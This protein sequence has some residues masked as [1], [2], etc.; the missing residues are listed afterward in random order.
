MWNEQELQILTSILEQIADEIAPLDGKHI[1]VLCSAAGDVVF[2]LAERMTSGKIVG[3]ELSSD[4]LALS[5][6]RAKEKGVESLVEFQAAEKTYIPFPDNTFDALI[7]EFILYPTP[8]PTDI[9]QPE[10][11][12]VLKPGGVMVLTDVITPQPY[13]EEVRRA[14]AE[15]GLTYL[16]EATK[17]DFRQWMVEAGLTEVRVVDVTPYA[18]QAWEWRREHDPQAANKQGYRYLLEDERFALGRGLFYIY[19]TGKKP[20]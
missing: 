1:L 20:G 12:R 4:L 9:G 8:L 5:Q 19:I 16:C 11:A 14:L 2:W 3:L 6:A 15:V 17:E 10:M 7:S 13:P 18:R